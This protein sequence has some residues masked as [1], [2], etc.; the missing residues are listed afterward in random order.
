MKLRT[1]WR[2]FSAL[3]DK[4]RFVW[5][6]DSKYLILGSNNVFLGFSQ[7]KFPKLHH[8]QETQKSK[9]K[10]NLLNK[11]SIPSYYLSSLPKPSAPTVQESKVQQSNSP[12]SSHRR[13]SKRRPIADDEI[14]L[15][16]PGNVWQVLHFLPAP[17]GENVVQVRLHC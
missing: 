8:H 13:S 10:F 1:P 12:K 3:W 15:V 14:N 6:S 7:K 16:V 2:L 17:L 4:G 11:C 9:T 5:L